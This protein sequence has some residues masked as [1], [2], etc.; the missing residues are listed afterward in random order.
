MTKFLA[1]PPRSSRPG[2]RRSPRARFKTG[3]ES[4]RGGKLARL[5]EKL[6]ELEA[7]LGTRRALRELG[8]GA[9][10]VFARGRGRECRACVGS[11][12]FRNLW[13]AVATRSRDAS[14]S[15]AAGPSFVLAR[16]PG[17][18]AGGDPAPPPR[19]KRDGGLRVYR[20]QQA[21]LVGAERVFILG[22]PADWLSAASEAAPGGGFWIGGRDRERLA[23]TGF[24]VRSGQQLREERTA[25][26]RAWCA[27]AQRCSRW[28]PRTRRMGGSASRSRSV[29]AAI[30]GVAALRRRPSRARSRAGGRATARFRRSRPRARCGFRRR[31]SPSS[32]RSLPEISATTLDRYSRCPFQALAL[33]SLAAQRPARS[34]LRSLARGERDSPARGGEADRR[35]RAREGASSGDSEDPS[36]ALSPREALDHAWHAAGRPPT[37]LFRSRRAEALPRE[38]GVCWKFSREG[39]RVPGARQSA[40]GRARSDAAQVRSRRQVPLVGKP[41]RIDE[42][43]DGLFVIDYKTSSSASRTRKICS[44]WAIGS[45][46][47]STRSR[48]RTRS[49]NRHRRCSSSRFRARARAGAAFSSNASTARRRA[50]SPMS[51]RT[52]RASCCASPGGLG[53]LSE[54]VLSEAQ[55]Y[56]DGRFDP[57]RKKA[58]RNA[59]AAPRPRLCGHGA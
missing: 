15:S 45:S 29:L 9:P 2:R 56:A 12:G 17:A 37:G 22:L 14:N 54:R 52:R 59:R 31:S 34:G 21:P 57:C 8:P 42:T 38:A 26:A 46:F 40:T 4:Y 53:E 23:S 32:A 48:R 55:A 49:A 44:V 7:A 13:S 5:H 27:T 18:P 25:A 36:F 1:E 43:A 24:A 33:R 41:D 39:G 51:A 6:G 19:E 10:R 20:L 11:S 47:R 58:K 16:T 3:F 28:T 30:T 35:S 50:S